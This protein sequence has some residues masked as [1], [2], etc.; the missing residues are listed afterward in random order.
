MRY[1]DRIEL[2]R[3]KHK[4]LIGDQLICNM[5]CKQLTREYYARHIDT[6][7]GLTA[8]HEYWK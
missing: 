3:T 6:F 7:E 2:L 1:A 5:V 8:L 4:K